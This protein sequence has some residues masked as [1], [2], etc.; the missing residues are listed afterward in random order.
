MENLDEIRA[1]EIQRL[2][3]LQQQLKQMPP[4]EGVARRIRSVMSLRFRL[5]D[6]PYEAA[7]KER[8]S[9]SG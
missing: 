2:R 1:R 6:N 5:G 8:T 7:E 9:N 3:E 4:S